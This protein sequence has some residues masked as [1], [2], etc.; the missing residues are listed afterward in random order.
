MGFLDALQG[1]MNQ[2][3]GTGEAGEQPNHAQ[4]AGGFVQAVEE[5]PGGLQGVLQH[6]E[7]NGMGDHV[8]QWASGDQQV[9]TPQHVEQGLGG[10]GLI[11]RTAQLTGLSPTMVKMGLAVAL[12]LLV[13]H[14]AS[15][16]TASAPQQG[17]LGSLAS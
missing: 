1:M 3:A 17:G 6:M 2:N 16:G 12:P 11:D 9:T 8:Q 15:G 10:T 4:V 14:Y 7:Q 13:R 5:Q